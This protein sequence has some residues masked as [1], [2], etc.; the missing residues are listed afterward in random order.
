[1]RF[2]SKNNI[3]PSDATK[4]REDME[5]LFLLFLRRF[6]VPACLEN[7]EMFTT[8]QRLIVAGTVECRNNPLF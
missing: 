4:E 5:P 6:H 8:L 3:P 7:L 1:M 2:Q